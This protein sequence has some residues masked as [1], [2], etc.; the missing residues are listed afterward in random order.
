MDLAWGLFVFSLWLVVTW[1]IGHPLMTW[2]SLGARGGGGDDGGPVE[3]FF[4]STLLG[5]L[6]LGGL[7]WLLLITGHLN[8]KYVGGAV[9][10]VAG[11]GWA[12]LLRGKQQQR[13]LALGPWTRLD[14]GL[15]C[16]A[17]VAGLLFFHPAEFLFGGGDAGV[18]I[19][20]GHI[21]SDQSGYVIKEAFLRDL[22]PSLYAGLF[23]ALPSASPVTYLRFPGLYLVDPGVGEI[24]PQFLPLHPVW[25][26]L[27]NQVLDVSASLYLTPLW[28]LLGVVAFSLFLKRLWGVGPALVGGAL[29]LVVPLQIYFARY[30]TAEALTQYLAWSLLYV[31]VRFRERPSRLWAVLGGVILG[32]LCM[33]RIDAMLFLVLVPGLI[34]IYPKALP[35][36][37]LA[38]LVGTLSVVMVAVVFQVLHLSYPYVVGTAGGLW[39]TM[40][41]LMVAPVGIMFL[42]GA[43]VFALSF[44][45]L[46][47][48]GRNGIRAA[49]LRRIGALLVLAGGVFDALVWPHVGESRS[50]PYWYS[51]STI[52]IANHLNLVRLAWYLSPLGVGLGV[53]GWVILLLKG[54]LRML[55]PALLVGF[56]FT[57]LYLYNIMNN[58]YHV[59]T[60]RRYVPVVVPFFLLG[61]VAVLQWFYVQHDRWPGAR[62]FAYSGGVLL[63]L[64]MGYSGRSILPTVEYR[65]LARQLEQLANQLP[66]GAILLFDDAS[67]VGVG[68][69]VGTPLQYL[70]GFTCFDL[71]EGKL[72]RGALQSALRGWLREGRPVYWVV[73]PQPALGREALPA[74]SPAWAF[75]FLVPR[76]EQTYGRFPVRHEQQWIPLEFYRLGSESHG[77]RCAS[78]FELD[79]GMLDTAYVI[80]GFHT[81]ERLGAQTVRWSD[82]RGILSL[83]CVNATDAE[84]EIRLRVGMPP[85]GEP[86]SLEVRL[87]HTLLGRWELGP[88]FHTIRATVSS[89][90][91]SQGGAQLVLI[92]PPWVP[93]DMG[94]GDDRRQLGV[95]VD[96]IRIAAGP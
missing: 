64:W 18:Y 23:R 31:L 79:V 59:Y 92:S 9:L 30:P 44:W 66:R 20:L 78:S 82:G 14:T 12:Y 38:W 21:W 50:V 63:F 25:L 48:G 45:L 47:R 34:L 55:W 86:M 76:L 87:D 57:G 72:D 46:T 32:S 90:L 51:G 36:E 16:I 41:A 1:I 52:P 61:V 4:V 11:T 54:K 96:W 29:L 91:L 88:G 89:T 53:L 8:L 24:L 74:G 68:A 75:E 13:V 28:A 39:R 35:R 58:P 81:K 60:M 77:Q 22:S 2:L 43:V 70:Y 33:T 27:V 84:T 80:E 15:L 83:P 69:T 19:N 56:G 10:V 94:L 6:V 7:A 26:A 85:L 3:R 71:Q 93:R 65:G 62:Y 40:I 95:M 37:P 49:W 73:G 42:L 5:T 17:V 67:P